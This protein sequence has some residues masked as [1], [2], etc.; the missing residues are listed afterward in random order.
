MYCLGNFLNFFYLCYHW[1]R[2]TN[3]F[4]D[5]SV[6]TEYKFIFHF[7]CFFIDFIFYFPFP[8]N[9]EFLFYS[10]DHTELLGFFCL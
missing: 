1:G 9:T 7:L 4:Y 10:E 6:A 8:V 3:S 2:R 5:D